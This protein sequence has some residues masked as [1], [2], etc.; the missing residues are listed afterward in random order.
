MN[1]NH[2]MPRM[3]PLSARR[4][5]ILS[6][7]DV[8]T[9][10]VV[11]LIAR[12]MPAQPSEMLRGRTHRCRVLGIG[13]QRSRGMKA[14]AVVDME[15]TENAI[16]MAVDAAERM[17]GV[18]V[19]GVIVNVTGGRLGSHLY[20]AKIG[21]GGRAVGES[22]VHRVLEAAA[23]RTAYQGRAVLHSLPNGFSL[24]STR[25]VRDPKGMIGE[26]LGADM[27]V[28][29][30]DAASARNLMLAVERCH[31]DI[32]A[33]VTSP[34]AAGLSALVDDEAEMGTAL[35]DMGGGTSSIGV[36]AQGHLTHV[37]AVA[38]G[39]N[40]VTMDIARGLSTRLGDAE[41]LKTLYGSCISS[42]S[43]DRETIAVA[44]SG[45][46]AEQAAHLPKSQLVRII[47][48]RV[49]EI[50]ELVRDRLKAAGFASQAGRRLV[51]TG[52]ASQL[53]G[54]PEAAR[55]IISS[56]VRIG[57]PLGVQGLPESAKNPAF[58]TV[59]GLLV[60]PQVAGIEHFEPCRQNASRA[61]GTDGYVS[62]VG[63]WLKESF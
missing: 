3:R 53:T 5:A 16:R 62:R 45:E 31:L 14:G 17:A 38:I 2:V 47:R 19:E 46:D 18:Q 52:G 41:R 1:S 28:V 55:R 21:I 25:G 8:G 50:L 36:F 37:D 61:T 29:S 27:H 22:D 26:E 7:L 10:K 44:Q 30:C 57:R 60:Y 58:S 48:P 11:C 35:V 40:H 4:S 49:E 15:E 54:L 20:N 23:S 56:Q 59:V 12:L 13:H 24:D 32:E 43:D 6:V 33:M 63:R 42:A 39:G 9:S 51:L 34:Y